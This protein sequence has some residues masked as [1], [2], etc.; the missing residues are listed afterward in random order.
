M[1]GF[2]QRSAFVCPV[3]SVRGAPVELT[4][5]CGKVIR[6]RRRCSNG[7][8]FWTKERAVIS[9]EKEEDVQAD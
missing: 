2:A 3:C 8:R 4:Q 6:R 7:H 9:E 5:P 1:T